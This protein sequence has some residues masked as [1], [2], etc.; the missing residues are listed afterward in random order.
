MDWNLDLP[1]DY[2]AP[3]E[4][5]E[6]SIENPLTTQQISDLSNKIKNAIQLPNFSL[7]LGETGGRIITFQGITRQSFRF[8][9]NPDPSAN[10]DFFQ[11]T[12]TQSSQGILANIYVPEGQHIECI[13]E[14]SFNE[15]PTAIGV[16][17][18]GGGMFYRFWWIDENGNRSLV[19]P[20]SYYVNL[21]SYSWSLIPTLWQNRRG[22]QVDFS[23][24]TI[25]ISNVTPRPVPR[26]VIPLPPPPPRIPPPPPPPPP[27]CDVQI[28]VDDTIGEGY[29]C[30]SFDEYRRFL[31]DNQRANE[32]LDTIVNSL[33]SFR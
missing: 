23:V 3:K 26:D 24:D 18:L 32:R 31:Q 29:F 6:R 11:S 22:I 27:V 4:Q 7:P 12:S 20:L 21:K 28:G 13:G 5:I 33:R 25:N 9:I 19:Y 15:W 17:R 14:G 2:P 10:W 16:P 1:F 30:M 8:V